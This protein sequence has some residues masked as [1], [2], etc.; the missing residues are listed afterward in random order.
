MKE[1]TCM[2]CLFGD[3]GCPNGHPECKTCGKDYKN[4][5]SERPKATNESK[6]IW[7]II[8]DEFYPERNNGHLSGMKERMIDI[9][10]YRI[11]NIISKK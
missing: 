6:R 1:R 2:Y 4:F 3:D 11:I 5:I 9:C 8:A 10:V 7:R